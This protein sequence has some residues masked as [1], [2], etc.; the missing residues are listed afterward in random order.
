MPTKVMNNKIINFLFYLILFSFGLWAGFYLLLLLIGNGISVSKQVNLSLNPFDLISLVVTIF[1]AVYVIKKLNK[2]SEAERIEKDL[3]IEDLGN[4][5]TEFGKEI[6]EILKQSSLKLIFVNSRLKTL[7]MR[8]HSTT[9]LIE[10]YKPLNDPSVVARLD[11]DIRDVRDL[12]TDNPEG[13]KG[14]LEIS[15]GRISL[16]AERK[17]QIE[18]IPNKV[19]EGIFQ[20]IVEINRK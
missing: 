5:K 2:E 14:N 16:E 12:L 20:I 4:F 18:A 7:R 17:S 19:S 3:L 11:T 6:I 10:K 8:F 13:A 1:L 15:G 9:N